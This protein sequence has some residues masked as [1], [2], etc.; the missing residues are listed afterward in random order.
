[1][2]ALSFRPGRRQRHQREGAEQGGQILVQQQDD[3]QADPVS[4]GDVP[5]ECGIEPEGQAE[6]AQQ[7]QATRIHLGR[8]GSHDQSR[9]SARLTKMPSISTSSGK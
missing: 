1:M 2:E 9:T 4:V 3:G 8:A 5:E 7:E 6:R